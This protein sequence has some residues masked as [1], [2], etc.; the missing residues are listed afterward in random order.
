MLYCSILLTTM[1]N[2][3]LLL[4]SYASNTRTFFIQ[5]WMDM[6]QCSTQWR[7][8]WLCKVSLK[9]CP[10]SCRSAVNSN[11]QHSSSRCTKQTMTTSPFSV[12]WKNKRKNSQ[13]DRRSWPNFPRNWTLW[14]ANNKNQLNNRS[15]GKKNV[16]NKDNN[17]NN[18]ETKNDYNKTRVHAQPSPP[19]LKQPRG[20]NRTALSIYQTNPHALKTTL[21]PRDIP[22]PSSNR[23]EETFSPLR[24]SETA[25]PFHHRNPPATQLLQ[26]HPRPPQRTGNTST[27]LYWCPGRTVGPQV[28]SLPYTLKNHHPIPPPRFITLLIKQTWQPL[29]SQWWW[30]RKAEG[31]SSTGKAQGRIWPIKT[32]S[33]NCSCGKR[34]VIRLA[35]G[36]GQFFKGFFHLLLTLDVRSTDCFSCCI[37]KPLSLSNIQKIKLTFNK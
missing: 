28:W 7:A 26:P 3:L 18:N 19:R 31:L 23:E 2:I 20:M 25:T 21:C 33:G 15:S 24:N 9:Q 5:G 37:S 34:C 6:S 35:R 11:S 36:G 32:W 12:S 8:A 1:K 22:S 16:K 27:A 29:R 10:W 13:N 14:N 30:R 17:S 4:M